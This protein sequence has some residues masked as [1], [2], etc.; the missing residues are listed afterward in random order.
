MAVSEEEA[1]AYLAIIRTI[2]QAL[3]AREP[4]REAREERWEEREEDCGGRED[5]DDFSS[6]RGQPSLVWTRRQDGQRD[7]MDR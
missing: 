1:A 6:L 3:A 5:G 2:S 7:R 4:G